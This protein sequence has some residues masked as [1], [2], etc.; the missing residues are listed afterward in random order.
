MDSQPHQKHVDKRTESH[1]LCRMREWR[2]SSL[3]DLYENQRLVLSRGVI[4]V[5]TAFCCFRSSTE[6]HRFWVGADT[7]L[8]E[9]PVP[10]G[11]ATLRTRV[12]EFGGTFTP[13]NH[14][15]RVRLPS[16]RLCPRR[17]RYRV[18]SV[19]FH[20]RCQY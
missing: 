20:V 4:R 10:G 19:L 17:D 11:S 18:G 8:K 7:S 16:G 2:G 6:G 1:T 13:V 12:I 14:V 15:C 3:L 5:Q 9:L